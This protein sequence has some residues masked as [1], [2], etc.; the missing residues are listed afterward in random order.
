MDTFSFKLIASAFLPVQQLTRK[1]TQIVCKI[2]FV[3]IIHILYQEYL[4]AQCGPIL[5][6]LNYIDVAHDMHVFQLTD[7][8]VLC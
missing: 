7:R 6:L 4:Q 3:R 1:C 5:K 2:T 8:D